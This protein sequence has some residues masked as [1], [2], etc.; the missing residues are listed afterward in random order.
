[1]PNNGYTPTQQRMLSILADGFPHTR[2]EL[3]G[4]LWDELGAL[5]NIQMH[6]SNLRKKLKPEGETVVCV[7]KHRR[8]H[9]QHVRLLKS[10]AV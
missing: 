9:Y 10:K 8:I 7:I 4:C 5:S 6:I 3:H 1:M 2:E